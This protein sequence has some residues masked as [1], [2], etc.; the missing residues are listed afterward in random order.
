MYGEKWLYVS[1]FMQLWKK[2]VSY[3]P[4]YAIFQIERPSLH[5]EIVQDWQESSCRHENQEKVFS[6]TQNQNQITWMKLRLW[7]L[8]VNLHYW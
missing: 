3:F 5:S 1:D 8:G 2:K 7:V 4:V 6:K